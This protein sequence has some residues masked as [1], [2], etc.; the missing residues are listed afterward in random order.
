[1]TNPKFLQAG[2]GK[3][4][5]AN[6]M[7]GI[8]NN[9]IKN[10][11]DMATLNN[12]VVTTGARMFGDL[13]TDPDVVAGNDKGL[14]KINAHG[15]V[16]KEMFPD[17]GSAF[18]D[19]F[20]GV[21]NSDHIKPKDRA[22]ALRAL[23]LQGEDVSSQQAQQ[24]PGAISNAAGQIVNR[25]PATGALSAA[26]SIS[27]RTQSRIPYRRRCY[28]RRHRWS[29]QRCGCLQPDPHRR[30]WSSSGD[31]DWRNKSLVWPRM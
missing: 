22:M 25:A 29:R 17:Q 20:L 8:K 2:P 18:I 23:Q 24:N 5:I 7:L 10:K 11:Q 6:A 21:I 16:F 12:N 9:Q 27:A 14:E 28:C 3:D 26:R 31:E 30:S 1:M 13:V 4:L 15:D 19:K